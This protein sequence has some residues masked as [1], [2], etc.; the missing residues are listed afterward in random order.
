VGGSP[1]SAA[2]RRSRHADLMPRLSVFVTIWPARRRSRRGRVGRVSR[3]ARGKRRGV[4]TGVSDR[5]FGLESGTNLQRARGTA[6]AARILRPE[7]VV[8]RARPCGGGRWANAR[9]RRPRTR[10][11]K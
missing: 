10:S 7:P 5:R 4:P 3:G 6:R 8:A 11:R 1:D 9:R 2:T